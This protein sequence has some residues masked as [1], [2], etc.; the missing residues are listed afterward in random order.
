M[1]ELA[2]LKL[3]VLD[4]KAEVNLLKITMPLSILLVDFARTLDISRQTLKY[5]LDNNYKSTVDFYKQNG[6][7][8]ISVGIL[9]H[10]KAH[11]EK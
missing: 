3:I 8:Y 9:Q 2:E 1:N 6:K 5:H 11:Y 10:I 4:L 7:I